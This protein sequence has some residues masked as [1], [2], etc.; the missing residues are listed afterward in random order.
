VILGAMVAAGSA[1]LSLHFGW[2]VLP[3]WAA[4]S[5]AAGIARSIDS[6]TLRVT[7][8]SYQIVQSVRNRALMPQGAVVFFLQGGTALERCRARFAIDRVSSVLLLVSRARS[9]IKVAWNLDVIWPAPFSSL[10]NALSLFS[11]DFLSLE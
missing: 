3:K 10:I 11:F 2:L 1:A 5:W 6:G 7:W 9:L 8:S 4:E